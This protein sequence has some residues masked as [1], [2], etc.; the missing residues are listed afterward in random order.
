[1]SDKANEFTF[2]D[3]MIS[4]LLANGWLSGKPE[5]YNRELALYGEDVLGFVKDTQDQ[6]WQKYC[7]LYPNDPEQRFLERVALQLNKAD[8]NA[9][10]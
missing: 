6:Q 7:K 9:A 8:P 3:D 2:Q 5:D 10:N 1:M 4:Q